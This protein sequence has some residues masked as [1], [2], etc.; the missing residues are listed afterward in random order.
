ML[1]THRGPVRSAQGRLA[2]LTTA[3][4]T[5]LLATP[6]IGQSPGARTYCNP[7]DIDYKYNFEQENRSL[8]AAGRWR[9][10]VCFAIQSGGM[11]SGIR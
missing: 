6:V 9:A 4:A 5:L 7:I 1:I 10:R 11:I 3:A 2:A 8:R